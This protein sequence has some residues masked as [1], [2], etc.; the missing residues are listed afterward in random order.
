MP[1][2]RIEISKRRPAEEQQHLIESLHDA[3]VEALRMP[4]HDRIIRLFEHRPD[5]FAVPQGASENYTLVEVTLFPGRSIEAKRSLYQ[6]IVSRFGEIGIEP[7]D[8]RI[9]LYEVP[10]ENWGI[11][12][13]VPAFE[14][15]LGYRVD[16]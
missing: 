11:R 16:V 15:D 6:G 12:G 8:I 14:V 9:L 2:A 3:M 1:I 5:H 4:E 7:N 13:G 10:M